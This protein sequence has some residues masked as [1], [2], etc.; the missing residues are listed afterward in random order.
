MYVSS[1]NETYAAWGIENSFGVSIRSSTAPLLYS[2]NDSADLMGSPENPNQDFP[3]GHFTPFPLAIADI[4]VS[5]DVP[6]EIMVI[7]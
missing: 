4:S 3:A 6:I 7:P 1:E 2:F 5:S